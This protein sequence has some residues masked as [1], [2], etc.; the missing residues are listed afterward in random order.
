M[1]STLASVLPDPSSYHS[2]CNYQWSPPGASPRSLDYRWGRGRF[3]V[4]QTHQPLKSDLYSDFGD[5]IWKILKN[6]KHDNSRIFFSTSRRPL[7][8]FEPRD[9]LPPSPGG[10]AHALPCLVIFLPFFL[11]TVF[12]LAQSYIQCRELCRMHYH[13]LIG[14]PCCLPSFLSAF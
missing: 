14:V 11:Q 3:Q 5:F 1:P 6:L 9:V 4:R 10:H 7:Q 2:Q 13:L 12:A 8:N